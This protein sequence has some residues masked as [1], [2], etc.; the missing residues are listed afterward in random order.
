[1]QPPETDTL[2]R[3]DELED[4]RKRVQQLEA[5]AADRRLKDRELE[6]WFRSMV[7]KAPIMMWI[8]GPDTLCTFFNKK[9]LEFRGRSMAQELGN[10]WSEGVHPDDLQ[11]CMETYISSFH[12]RQDFNME[13]RLRRADGVYVW[14]MD[15]GVPRYNP[16]G[17]FAGYVGCALPTAGPDRAPSLAA[18]VPLT[19]REQQVL[20]LIAEGNSTKELAA[21][22]GISYKTADSHRTKIMDKLQ[23]HETASLVRYAIRM[24]LV[25]P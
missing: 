23:V 11:R 6:D 5:E 19:K 18:G 22:L 25:K 7:D 15:D 2:Q 17:A 10:G 9:W 24:G 3:T 20:T 21:I 13:Y 4:L 12:L 1:M 16:D 8:S 14:V